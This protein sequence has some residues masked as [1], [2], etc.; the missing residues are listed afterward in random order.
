M[1]RN[2]TSRL[3][4]VHLL[5]VALSTGLVLSFV[6]WQTRSV[7]EAEV[8]EVV[9]AEIRGLEDDYRRHGLPG[10]AEAVTRRANTPGEEGAVYLLTDPAGRRIAGNLVGWPRSVAPGSGWVELELTRTDTDRDVL[11]SAVSFRLSGGER[12]LVGR[13]ARARA[14]FDRTLTQ[15]LI[16]A[17]GVTGLLALLTG[18]LL[19]RLVLSRIGDIAATAGEIVQG[20]MTRRVAVRGT[21]DEFDRLAGTLNR[22]LDRIETLVG[23]LRMVTDSVAHDLRSPLT[24]L[25]AHLEEALDDTLPGVERQAR[26]ERAM[27]EADGV[28][29]AF[30]ALLD[31]ARAEAG[32][33]RDQFE[34]VDLARLVADVADLYA[35]MAED[36]SVTLAIAGAPA[37]VSGHPQ[38]LANALANLVENALKHASAGSEV[39]LETAAAADGV[40]LTVSDR[41]PGVPAEERDRV[42][43]RF[44]RLDGSRGSPGAGLGL[45]LVAAVARMHGAG[46]ALS[47]NAPGLRVTLAFPFTAPERAGSGALAPLAAET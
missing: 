39:R 42:L 3:I 37:S 5:L 23:D 16:W 1:L 24:R 4:A 11:A 40:E 26:I 17:L 19:S 41:G 47:D 44:V 25:R 30:T 13:D 7:I 18:W 10:L 46:L 29:R 15:A 28:L 9:E 34:P 8:R 21:G 20:S 31:I 33:G 14:A 22:M 38:L 27:A 36:K 12:L 32:M 2:A 6:Y 45:S 43:S 35:P